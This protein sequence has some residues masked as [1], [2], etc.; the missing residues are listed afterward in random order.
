[1]TFLAAA[2]SI[3]LETFSTMSITSRT[4]LRAS[5]VWL[6]AALMAAWCGQREAAAVTPDSPEVKQAAAKALAWL[7]KQ[8]EDRLGGKC[9]IGLCFFKAEKGLNHPKVVAAQRAC[10]LAVATIDSAE[11][12]QDNYSVGL[13]LIF[14]CETNPNR[15]RALA[16]RY[17]ESMLRR[18][19]ANG[20]WG[21]P[22]EDLGD[23]SQTQYPTL[24]LWLAANNGIDVPNTAFE[25][26][27]AFL[28]RVQDPSGGWSYKGKDP[29]RFVRIPQDDVRPPVT[30]AGLGALY[31]CCDLL[32]IRGG[33][34]AIAAAP[35]GPQE[36]LP[37][38]ALKPVGDNLAVIRRKPYVTRVIDHKLARGALADGDNWM[39]TRLK[40]DGTWYHYFLYA[41]ERYHSFR[42]L[43]L[44]KTESEPAWFTEYFAHLK[45]TQSQDGSWEGQDNAVVATSFST[46][47]LLRSAR[48]TISHLANTASEGVLLGGM[49]LPK[50]TADLR[51]RDGKIVETPFAGTVDELIALISNPDHPDF[52]RLNDTT[53]AVALDADVT[54]R[55]G[56][57]ARLRS[58]V[59]SGSFESRLIAIRTLGR[60]RELDNVPLLIF[61]MNDADLRIVRAADQGLAFISRKFGGVGLRDGSSGEDVKAAIAAWKAWYRSIRPNAEFLD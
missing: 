13:A 9:L 11:S 3:A 29:G 37:P 57:I 51:E 60:V 15:N 56:Q 28:L 34:Q 47:F 22:N 14:L 59:N 32:G 39:Q 35:Q 40:T 36:P 2:A 7:E 50:N 43:S 49:G 53:A 4:P 17:V 41:F 5:A 44:E 33:P 55:S 61:A 30:A 10:E 12:P 6:A 21:Y 38:A 52:I 24:G 16:T 46:L 26:A 42:E 20:G 23:L 48:K 25:R 19:K 58:I 8:D 1:L 54:K 18:Q 27:C 31:I 45:S